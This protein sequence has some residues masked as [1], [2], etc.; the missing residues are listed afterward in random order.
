M[1]SVKSEEGAAALLSAEDIKA[2]ADKDDNE[3]E[4]AE[5]S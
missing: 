3:N 1:G 5:R 2:L 4:I